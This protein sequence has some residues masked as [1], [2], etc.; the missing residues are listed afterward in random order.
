MTRG[1]RDLVAAAS[2]VLLLAGCSAA[3]SPA[4]QYEDGYRY[5]RDE[6]PDGHVGTPSSQD[7]L[8]GADA[9]CGEHAETDGV[10]PFPPTA[11]WMNGCQDGARG[12]PP[13]PYPGADTSRGT[14]GAP[15]RN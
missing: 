3:P 6:I 10:E 13:S 1:V 4:E 12:L 9:E 2:L 11:D 14:S 15:G 5:G 8:A 7:D